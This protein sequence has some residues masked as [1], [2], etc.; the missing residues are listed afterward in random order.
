MLQHDT[1]HRLL[2][3]APGGVCGRGGGVSHEGASRGGG[4]AM[5]QHLVRGAHSSQV[6]RIWAARFPGGARALHHTGIECKPSC[7]KSCALLFSCTR[8]RTSSMQEKKKSVPQHLIKKNFTQ[9][10]ARQMQG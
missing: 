5:Q 3:R 10:S 9:R 6:P 4:V 1:N 2:H 8:G 7:V